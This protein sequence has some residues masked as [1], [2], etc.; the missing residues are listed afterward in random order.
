[1]RATAVAAEFAVLRVLLP[2]GL[3]TVDQL[4][5]E[6]ALTS[7]SARGAV[8]RLERR[9]LIVGPGRRGRWEITHRGRGEWASKGK[10]FTL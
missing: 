6:A 5:G 1:M 7:S 9:G 2:G 8:A 10:R 4:A 3:L